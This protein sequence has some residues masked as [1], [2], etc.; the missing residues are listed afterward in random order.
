MTGLRE[1]ATAS[2]LLL[3]GCFA[4]AARPGV[5][6]RQAHEAVAAA[7]YQLAARLADSVL[8]ISDNPLTRIE[9][10]DVATRSHRPIGNFD[11]CERAYAEAEEIFASTP[12]LSD[13][14]NFSTSVGESYANL[15]LNHA[16]FQLAMGRYNDCE[17]TLALL[18]FTP[19]R[20]ASELE[21]RRLG[22][23]ASLAYRQGYSDRALTIL[24]DAIARAG[25]S[26]TL[27]MLLQNRGFIL[28][29]VGRHE[30]AEKDLARAIEMLGG[31][32]RAVALSNHAMALSRS[33]NHLKA[34]TEIDEAI[35]SLHNLCGSKD[36]EYTAALCKKGEIQLAAGRTDE[37]SATMR[38]FFTKERQR[39][40]TALGAMTPQMRLDYWTREKQILSRCFLLGDADPALMLDV[41]LMRRETSLPIMR[42]HDASR[43]RATGADLG[44]RLRPG[45]AAVAFVLCPSPAGG[46]VYAAAVL[47]YGSD[48]EFVT[49]FDE[50]F[51]S[52]PGVAGEISLTEA[53][54]SEDPA[55][56][57]V[58]YT[59]HDIAEK[60]WRPVIDVL[61]AGIRVIHFAP[62]GILHLIGIENLPFDNSEQFEMTRHFSLLD[63][64][65]NATG[66]S[67]ATP[68]F[69]TG[70][71]PLVAGGLNYDIEPESSATALSDNNMAY[72]ELRR[73]IGDG[74]SGSGIFRYLP[75]TAAE[76][77]LVA[78]ALPEAEKR[79]TLS[80]EDLKAGAHGRP[81]LHIA[82]HGYSLDCGTG[83][84][85][86]LPGDSTAVDISL[87]RSGIALSGAN[88]M[89]EVDG[90]DD[91]ILS[92]REI[93]DLDLSGTSLVVL[94]A[95][96]T[97]KGFITDENAS[98]LIRALKI[99]GAGTIV[100]SLW[101]VDD[102]ATSLFMSEFHRR[103]AA[104]DPKRQAFEAARSK[105]AGLER[106]SRRR[107][108][109]AAALAGRSDGETVTSKPY[110]DPWYWAPFIIIDP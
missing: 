105:V 99:A 13:Y 104:G 70:C 50:S 101:E 108:F 46:N 93:C 57:N 102:K 5:L 109:D 92:A 15:L 75:C 98:G 58:L 44:R 43:L 48:P 34:I 35:D 37:A 32:E 21:L 11:A 107:R 27:P 1:I 79:T 95:C 25:D 73:S 49:L 19:G 20:K 42:G 103:L 74:A 77:D 53:V 67:D 87:L 100:A 61:P 85:M 45:E 106:Q 22:T 7:E 96:Q 88:V 59:S 65:G 83:Q 97:A 94:S 9:A 2:I 41:A 86:T 60:I 6:L 81:M 90:R 36:A 54:A 62:E 12:S 10:L 30:E 33:G 56:K 78:E 17:A 76:A 8:S 63:I 71:R 29:A 52:E 31:R 39:L 84:T 47:P 3:T 80:E 72:S 66:K 26:P 18:E 38:D 82:T 16:Q 4:Y 68:R 24:S 89:G 110:A 23:E 91:G 51:V 14:A 64:S 40:A 55:C 69:R 28:S